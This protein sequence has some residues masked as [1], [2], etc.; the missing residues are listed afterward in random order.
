MSYV[1]VRAVSAFLW[2]KRV[3]VIVHAYDQ[4]S[5]FE[6]DPEFRRSGLEIAPSLP[7]TGRQASFLPARRIFRR[8][9]SIGS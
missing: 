2:G 1:P 7:G 6:Y 4:Y 9:L 8:G 3:G 5:R